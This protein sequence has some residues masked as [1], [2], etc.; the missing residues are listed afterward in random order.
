M[1]VSAIMAVLILPLSLLLPMLDQPAAGTSLW[2]TI[3]NAWMNLTH[4]Q[5]SANNPGLIFQ[6]G[7]PTTNFF[8]DELSI[9]GSVNLPTGEVL[10]YTSTGSQK[11][12]YLAGFRYDEFDGHPWTACD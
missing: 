3:D 2:N 9:T 11:S 12:H 8:G 10:D 4:G 5:F 6:S 1:A 7:Q